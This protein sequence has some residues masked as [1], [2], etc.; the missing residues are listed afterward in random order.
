L[1]DFRPQTRRPAL[2]LLDEPTNHLDLDAVLWLE[3]YLANH[4]KGTLLV[5]SHDADFLNTVCTDVI[6]MS[7]D[8]TLLC[9]GGLCQIAALPLGGRP[10]NC[11][12]PLGVWHLLNKEPNLTI[13]E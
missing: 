3:D 5:V 8:S 2:L 11:R 10:G 9:A 6:Q 1:S 4:F 13:F 12:R 7:F